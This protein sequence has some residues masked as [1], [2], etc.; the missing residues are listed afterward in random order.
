VT[1]EDFVAA[2]QDASKVDLG[3]FRR[4]YARA[5]TPH[6]KAEGTYDAAAKRYTLTLAQSLAPTAYERK[7]QEAGIAIDDGPLHI[8]VA[9]GL[10]LPDGSDAFVRHAS[11]SR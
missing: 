4:W 11:T 8:P 10:V 6:L 7:L 5:G 3:Q 1:C 9:V 2:M